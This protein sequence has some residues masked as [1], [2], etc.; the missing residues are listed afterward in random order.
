MDEAAAEA[1]E[2]ASVAAVGLPVA[3]WL[4][5]DLRGSVSELIE[6]APAARPTSSSSGP[7]SSPRSG[8]PCQPT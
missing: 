5:G 6:K 7:P 1:A 3:G 4:S 2:A 8:L